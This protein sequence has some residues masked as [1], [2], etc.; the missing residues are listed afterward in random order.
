MRTIDFAVELDFGQ[1]Q[2]DESV[3]ADL[4]ALLTTPKV[5]AES[6][7]RIHL[8]F[9]AP[10][11]LAALLK[12]RGIDPALPVDEQAKKGLVRAR[13]I[14]EKR[15]CVKSARLRQ[16]FLNNAHANIEVLT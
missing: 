3:I 8:R 1:S 10:V 13:F 11:S 4:K 12:D 15:F 2:A 16:R 7:G 14:R 9:D 5:L 6:Y